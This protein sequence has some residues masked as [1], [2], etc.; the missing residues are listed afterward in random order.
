MLR[1]TTKKLVYYYTYYHIVVEV[2]ILLSTIILLDPNTHK[3]T[4]FCSS[5]KPN[6]DDDSVFTPLKL[7]YL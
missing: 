3:N 2:A 6:V 4:L 5:S 1:E 7:P